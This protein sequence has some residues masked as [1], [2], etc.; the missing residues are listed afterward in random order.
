[1][2]ARGLNLNSS[3][4]AGFHDVQAGVWYT[5]YVN[6]AASAGLINGYDDYFRPDDLITREE[7]AVIIVKA[8][9]FQGGQSQRNGLEQF[10]DQEDISSW[11][12]DY[13]DQ[14]VGAGLIYGMTSNT[15]VPA[16]NATRA[17]AAS[18]LKRLINMSV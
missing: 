9:L 3:V 13:V 6:A 14:A 1:M 18:L 15:F 17:Q 11:A 2:I 8:Y 5:N 4:S 12:R 16:E 10:I 7:M